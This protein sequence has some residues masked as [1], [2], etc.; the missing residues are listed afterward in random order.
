MG[1]LLESMEAGFM[2]WNWLP[3]LP[4]LALWSWL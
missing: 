4:M 2:M 3:V 1:L